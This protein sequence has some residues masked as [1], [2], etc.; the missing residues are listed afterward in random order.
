MKEK[1]RF[2]IASEPAYRKEYEGLGIFVKPRLRVQT[3][4]LD[5]WRRERT[6]QI[7]Q[8]AFEE[9]WPNHCPHCG[10]GGVVY[11]TENGAPHG[12]GFWPMEMTD[13]CPFCMGQCPLCG[14]VFPEDDEEMDRCV[15]C[16]WEWEKDNETAPGEFECDCWMEEYQ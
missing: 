7:D 6:W 16:G 3:H 9:K 10:G 2:A 13:P 5:C 11:Y 1:L 8:K 4:T 12:A 15:V 14:T